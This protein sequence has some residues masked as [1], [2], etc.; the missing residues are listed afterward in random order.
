VAGTATSNADIK[1]V[2]TTQAEIIAALK[3]TDT[4]RFEAGAGYYVDN[5]DGAPGYSQK[6]DGYNVYLQ[7]LIT[8]AP[9]VFLCPE[10][11]LIDYMDDRSGQDEGYQWYVGAKWQ[12]NF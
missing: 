1:D 6:D 2:Y 10:I 9:G 8:M 3:F 5:A 4:L 7:A 12:I 11:G